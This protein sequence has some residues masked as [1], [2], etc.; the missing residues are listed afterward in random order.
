MVKGKGFT[1]I[2]LMIFLTISGLLLVMAFIGS[3]G[4]ARQARFSDAVNS[5]HSL[6][7]KQYESVLNGVNTRDTGTLCGGSSSAPGSG[8]CIMLG[9]VMSFADVSGTGHITVR[10]VISNS[11]SVADIGMDTDQIAAANPYVV[12][13]TLEDIDLAWG[14]TFQVTSR[15]T[16]ATLSDP[17]KDT[18]R[19]LIRNIAFLRGP[20]NSQ[21]VTYMFYS[22]DMTIPAIN[23]G[24]GTSVANPVTTSNTG[25]VSAALCIVN[26]A[27][28]PGGT[29]PVAA[30]VV[31]SGA[32]RA[33]I[34]TDF[35]P[36]RGSGSVEMVCDT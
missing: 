33:S 24:M 35:D 18:A 9:R 2:E 17:N 14:A 8:S 16:L 22:A 29:S 21:I 34:E 32:G 30:I 36:Q 23:S 25:G 11:T 4:M 7:L 6:I 13:Q 10:P 5:L 31:G 3:N 1:V 12:D 15:S 19:G 20:N 28:Y 27:D 26:L